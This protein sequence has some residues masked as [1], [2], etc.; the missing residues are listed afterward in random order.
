MNLVSTYFAKVPDPR[1]ASNA[2]IH[3]LLEML[4][5]ALCA[6]LSGAETFA[7]MERFGLEKHQWLRERLGLRLPGDFDNEFWPTLMLRFGPLRSDVNR[8]G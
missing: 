3:L 8:D 5:I 6:V 4:T 2:Q 1:G 7:D